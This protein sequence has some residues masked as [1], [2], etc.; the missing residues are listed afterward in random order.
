MEKQEITIKIGKDGQSIEY[1]VKGASGKACT[2]KDFTFLDDIFSQVTERKYTT[3][4]HDEK[5]QEVGINVK[6]GG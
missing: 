3:E 5:G 4:Y 1:K 6:K 2:S